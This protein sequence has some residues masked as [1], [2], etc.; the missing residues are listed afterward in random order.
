VEGGYCPILFD[1]E[2]AKTHSDLL[3]HVQLFRGLPSETLLRII[4]LSH[5]AS[6]ASGEFFFNEGDPARRF[7]VLTRGHVKLIQLSPDGHQ[8]VLR[9]I[10]PGEAFGSAGAFGEAVYPNAAQSAEAAEALTWPSASIRRLIEEE[11][12]IALNAVEFVSGRLHDLQRRYRQMM[13]E[14]VELRV[15]RAILRLVHE[16]GRR[17]EGGVE[18]DFPISRQDIAELT[19]TTLYT[20]SRL[21]SSWESL[22]IVRCGRQK[23]ALVKPDALTAIADD[24]PHRRF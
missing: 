5:S 10:G 8:V 24:L 22:G 16:A 6:V 20:V 19:G 14:R 3:G 12:V 18:V 15:A 23:I 1:W 13:T 17:A 11:P 9:I 7:L 21:L 4:G 2:A